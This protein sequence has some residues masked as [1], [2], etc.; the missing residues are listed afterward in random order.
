MEAE[1]GRVYLTWH[2]VE[3]LITKVVMQLNTP[4]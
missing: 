3:E 1:M 4:V 2:D